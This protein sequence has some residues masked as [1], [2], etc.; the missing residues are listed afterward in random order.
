MPVKFADTADGVGN[1][2]TATGTLTGEEHIAALEA[3]LSQP[4]EDLRRYRYSLIDLTAVTELKVPTEDVHTVAR[5]CQ[6]AAA[7]NPDV[8]VAVAA[9][10]DIGFGLS[11]MFEILV[12]TTDW[13]TMVFRTREAAEEWI[14]NRVRER[15]G[16]EDLTIQSA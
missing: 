12:D 14:R 15:F 11:R 8:I 4:E 10:R 16:I 1:L 13:E 3:H 6:A 7:I 5:M 2:T 9:E